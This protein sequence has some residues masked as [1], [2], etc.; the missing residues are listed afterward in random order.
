MKIIFNKYCH[1]FVLYMVFSSLLHADETQYENQID[2]Q[3]TAVQALERALPIMIIFI[4]SDCDDC[5]TVMNEFIT[6]M[7]ISG[8]YDDKV[9]MRTL[10]LDDDS[11]RDF[12][13]KPISSES[14][15]SRYGLEL[16]PTVSLVDYLG[17]ELSKSV[18]GMS[19]IE[20]YSITLD[21][22]I[23][24]SIGRLRPAGSTQ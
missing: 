22:A 19:N 13:G 2:L 10:N 18:S 24:Q 12:D 15:S 23:E 6:P 4:T 14:L 3:M 16:T 5:D 20:Y 1:I 8:E 17:N 9:I 7:K 11:V 21:E